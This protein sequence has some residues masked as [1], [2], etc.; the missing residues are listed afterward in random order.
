MKKQI[1]KIINNGL[2]IGPNILSYDQEPHRKPLKENVKVC[3]AWIRMWIDKRKTI[4]KKHGSYRLKHFVEEMNDGHISNGAFI[5]A[6]FEEGF[7]IKP[8]GPNSP[9]AYFNMSFVRIEKELRK[10][11]ENHY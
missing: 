4:N 11:K 6:A 3:R 9:N 1:P 7:I 2:Y 8:F 5:Q 10:R